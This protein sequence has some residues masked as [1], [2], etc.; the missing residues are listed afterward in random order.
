MVFGFRKKKKKRKGLRI[1]PDLWRYREL[2]RYLKNVK[3]VYGPNSKEY[4][5]AVKTALA[6]YYETKAE[7]KAAFGGRY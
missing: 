4:K 3:K 7:E 2:A 6:I 1:P 5:Q